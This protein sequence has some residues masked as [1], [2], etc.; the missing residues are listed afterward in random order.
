[1]KTFWVVDATMNYQA[2]ENMLAFVKVNNLFDKLYTDQ[3]FNAILPGEKNPY[4][5]YPA[6]G[7]NFQFGMEFKF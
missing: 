5:W 1:M 3:L 4:D 6:P 2:T 7:R